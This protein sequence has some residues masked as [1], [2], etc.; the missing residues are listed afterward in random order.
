M[1]VALVI[2][3]MVFAAALPMQGV[4]LTR[5]RA[6]EAQ[7]AFWGRVEPA[8]AALDELSSAAI[9]VDAS[10]TVAPNGAHFLAYAPRYATAPLPV[11]ISIVNGDTLV[12][13]APGISARSTL[14]SGG[15]DLRLRVVQSP[16]PVPE[17]KPRLA[18]LAIDARIKGSWA[19]LIRAPIG[20]DAPLACL[21]DAISRVCR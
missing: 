13:T 12:V 19:P 7:S 15:P 8:R 4:W 2:M 14:L 16:S 11:D 5:A 18:A 3:G 21:F 17:H 9:D 20:S 1:L 6:I 10:F